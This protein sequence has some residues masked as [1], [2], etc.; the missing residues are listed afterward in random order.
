M[1]NPTTSTLLLTSSLLGAAT[2]LDTTISNSFVNQ[3]ST[4]GHLIDS[5]S[6]KID[7]FEG[8][9]LWYGL[10][11]GCGK[12]FCGIESWS[13]VDLI[14]WSSNGL[15]FDP[16][17]NATATICEASG[18]CGRPHIV[19][20]PSTSLY[21]LWVNAGSP[22]YVIFTSPSPASGYVLEPSRALV[23]H[24]PN[25][26]T[27]K[28]GDFSVAVINGTGYLAYSLIDFKTLGASIWPPFKQSM[29][30]QEL[31]KDFMNTTGNV[32]N[33][34]PVGDLVDYQAE[35]PDIFYRNGY[36]YISSSNTC[37]FCQGT[38]L[39]MYRAKDITGPWIRQ[40]ISGDTCGGQTSGVL[41]IPSSTGEG[42]YIHQSDIQASAPL[43]GSRNAQHG[44]Q[45][46]VLNFNSDGSVQD[47]DCS[48][49]LS[50]TVTLPTADRIVDGLATTAALGSGNDHQDY[51]L[52]CSIPQYAF[53]Q[54]FSS[55]QAGNLTSIGVNLAGDAPTDNVNLTI[56]RYNNDTA[57]ISA[58]YAWE[59][60]STMEVTPDNLSASLQ[61]IA[62][63]VGKEVAAGDKLGIA[64]VSL[65]ITP[66][67]VAMRGTSQAY[68]T[69]WAGPVQGG[70]V[71][72]RVLGEKG[73]NGTGSGGVLYALG[74]NQVSL[75]GKNGDQIPILEV[76]G[77]E[78]KWYGTVE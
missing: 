24:Q 29:Y 20:S 45:F 7:Y 19:Y 12:A 51:Y 4:D 61:A 78:L 6:G 76:S 70:F 46:Q 58:F 63:P 60:L 3:F 5:T 38:I 14:T 35:S 9:Y 16:T 55:S 36:Y 59:T 28:A 57:L 10:N 41:T 68:A 65:G 67:C 40:I 39:I 47:L 27:D 49:S 77:R 71:T 1:R 74:A 54:T 37:G 62:V 34:I 33:V 43:A 18:D 30:I 75:R 22:G 17:E 13:S 15:L 66:V 72:G 73:F 48:A 69:G 52:N 64:I 23:G 21:I 42:V 31:T 26:E 50:T 2:C 8:Q 25:L 32:T 44:H 56:F 11:F 53:Y